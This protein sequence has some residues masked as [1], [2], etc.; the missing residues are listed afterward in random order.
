ML[1]FKNL[2]LV[3][4]M[5]I[6]YSCN[7]EDLT[8][9]V[10]DG[11]PPAPP[12]NLTIYAAFDGQIGLSWHAN[13]ELDIYGY[14]IYRSVN[15]S[16]HFVFLEITTNTFYIDQ[17][18]EYD[19]VYYYKIRAVD[20]SQ[21]ESKFSS[22]VFAQPKNIYKPLRP[23]FVKINARNF[24][25]EQYILINWSPPSDNDIS[26]YE[27]YRDTTTNIEISPEKLIDTSPNNYYID[28]KDLRMLQKYTYVIIAVD[29]GG[30]KSN[31]TEPV[32][33]M[34]LNAP[35]LL[36]PPN[37][38][39]LNILNEFRIITVSKPAEYKLVIQSNPIYGT[40]NE[41]NFT[42]NKIDTEISLNVSNIYLEPYKTYYWRILTYTNNNSEPNSSSE[43][44]TFT[45]NPR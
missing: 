8:E 45:Y 34:I 13:S 39:V 35:L 32:S 26:H 25:N 23:Q 33:D 11:L 6:F 12:I 40:V 1:Y 5:F 28:K 42:S 27:I 22:I 2:V 20:K 9:S 41:Y 18:L 10:D 36:Y 37:H 21:R 19:S 14:S 43:L 16:T 4:I 24:N 15:D 44:F 29:K 17:N 30:L 7:R 38:A 3:I 31:P